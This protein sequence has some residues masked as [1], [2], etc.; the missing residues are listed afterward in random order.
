[1]SRRLFSIVIILAI[2]LGVYLHI[3]KESQSQSVLIIIATLTFLVFSFG[4]QGL[5]A[6]SLNPPRTKGE[7]MRFPLFMWILWAVMFLLFVFFVLPLYCPDFFA[8][9]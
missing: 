5:I 7:L 1:M 2:A 8:G 4:V 9:F 3:T 6:H